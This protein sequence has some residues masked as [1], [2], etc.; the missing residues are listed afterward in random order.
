MI[1]NE[2]DMPEEKMPGHAHMNVAQLETHL[3]QDISLY[4]NDHIFVIAKIQDCIGSQSSS[5]R[6]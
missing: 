5:T 2:F 6:A 4:E 3:K 1:A